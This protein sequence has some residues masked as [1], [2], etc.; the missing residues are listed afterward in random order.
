MRPSGSAD[1]S[2]PNAQAGEKRG[3]I[4]AHKYEGSTNFQ[5]TSPRL[6]GGR[7]NAEV[8]GIIDVRRQIWRSGMG[9]K[10]RENETILGN[11]VHMDS[12][13]C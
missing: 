12:A 11:K 5:R 2:D 8:C 9:Q 13:L 4:A 10:E 6:R 3:E 1:S 7:S